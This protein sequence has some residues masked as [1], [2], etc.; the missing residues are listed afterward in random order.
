[1]ATHAPGP[2]A[3]LGNDPSDLHDLVARFDEA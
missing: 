1:M 2:G 3:S